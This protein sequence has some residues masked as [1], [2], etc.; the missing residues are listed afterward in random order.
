MEI[1]EVAGK[2][3]KGMSVAEADSVAGMDKGAAAVAAAVDSA[4]F[5]PE[6]KGRRPGE[7][8]HSRSGSWGDIE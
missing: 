7:R 8:R 6:S 2:G 1:E 4:H 5:A 3:D